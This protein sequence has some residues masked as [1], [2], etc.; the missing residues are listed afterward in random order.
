[1]R[2]RAQVLSDL[3]G[4]GLGLLRIEG[5]TQDLNSYAQADPKGS[6]DRIRKGTRPYKA[7]DVSCKLV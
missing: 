5:P 1:M 4:S 7:V 6:K 3:L 2:S